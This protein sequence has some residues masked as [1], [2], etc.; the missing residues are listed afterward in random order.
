[1]N[2]EVDCEEE[3]GDLPVLGEPVRIEGGLFAEGGG[4]GI[5]NQKPVFRIKSRI[6]EQKAGFQNQKAVFEN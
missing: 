6:S 3:L 1:M 2:L 5:Q 4:G